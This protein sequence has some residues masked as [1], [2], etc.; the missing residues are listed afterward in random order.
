MPGELLLLLLLSD[1]QPRHPAAV[2]EASELPEREMAEA[3]LPPS[4]GDGKCRDAS[5]TSYGNRGP[6]ADLP[7]EREREGRGATDQ[8]YTS[9]AAATR[10][11]LKTC[12]R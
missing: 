4:Q 9:H 12:V 11:G 2:G 8:R 10:G 1:Q 3:A 6:N 7:A 5:E